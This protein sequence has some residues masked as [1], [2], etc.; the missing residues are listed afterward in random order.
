[1]NVVRPSTEASPAILEVD[2]GDVAMFTC[3]VSGSPLPTAKWIEVSTAMEITNE[4]QTQTGTCTCV[5]CVSS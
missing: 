1:M 4:D 2:E 3:I 5:I